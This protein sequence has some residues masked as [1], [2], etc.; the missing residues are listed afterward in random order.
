MLANILGWFEQ[1]EWITVDEISS[2]SLWVFIHPYSLLITACSPSPFFLANNGYSRNDSIFQLSLRMKETIYSCFAFLAIMM[3]NANEQ[4]WV[5]VT[6]VHGAQEYAYQRGPSEG[7][8]W[9]MCLTWL[10][11]PRRLRAPEE[12]ASW[13]WARHV[14]NPELS[15]ALP[16]RHCHKFI[17]FGFCSFYEFKLDLW[18]VMWQQASA[19]WLTVWVGQTVALWQNSR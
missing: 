13:T 19:W 7:T 6:N 18:I 15:I 17:C 12:D 5:P 9:E 4:H 14:C 8:L 2:F 1:R 10:S 16:L 11:P 3:K